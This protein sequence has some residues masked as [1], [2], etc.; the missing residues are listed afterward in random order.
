MELTQASNNVESYLTN[1]NP[2]IHGFEQHT[3]AANNIKGPLIELFNARR[4]GDTNAENKAI[5]KIIDASFEL[6]ERRNNQADAQAPSGRSV[7][8]HNEFALRM[9]KDQLKAQFNSAQ[10]PSEKKAIVAK[11]LSIG[12]P[13]GEIPEPTMNVYNML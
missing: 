11:A 4:S 13:L 9:G 6:A 10:S 7:T 1:S 8:N 12:F 5:E 2:P 3:E